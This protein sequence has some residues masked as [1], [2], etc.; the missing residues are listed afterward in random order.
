MSSITDYH[1]HDPV[2]S[3]VVDIVSCHPSS[4]VEGSQSCVCEL[5]KDAKSSS[6]IKETGS[7]WFTG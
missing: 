3:D 6:K 2:R 4:K 5:I 1:K 7:T